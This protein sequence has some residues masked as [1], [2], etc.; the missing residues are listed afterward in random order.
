MHNVSIHIVLLAVKTLSF[1][2]KS[3]T[4]LFSFF[5][6]FPQFTCSSMFQLGAQASLPAASFLL[7]CLGP[8]LHCS[9]HPSLLSCQHFPQKLRSQYL[10]LG[11]PVP[12]PSHTNS[13]ARI[14]V[15]YTCSCFRK[16]SS[17][18]SS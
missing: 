12:L 10:P 18:M 2:E 5:R 9:I 13:T 7:G 16:I 15:F 1:S 17:C 8:H 11:C 4:I 6:K 14:S 3:L